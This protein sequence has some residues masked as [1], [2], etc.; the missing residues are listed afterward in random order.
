MRS[1]GA[2]RV[3][4]NAVRNGPNRGNIFTLRQLDLSMTGADDCF[5][6]RDRSDDPGAAIPAKCLLQFRQ[7]VPK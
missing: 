7:V 4:L 2:V 1:L 3:N 6:R 5:G